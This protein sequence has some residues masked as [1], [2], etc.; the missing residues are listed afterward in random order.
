[1]TQLALSLASATLLFL[2]ALYAYLVW[3]FIRVLKAKRV[4]GVPREAQEH[5]SILRSPKGNPTPGPAP[6][7]LTRLEDLD[8][9]LGILEDGRK[10]DT[11]ALDLLRH[12]WEDLLRRI[13]KLSGIEKRIRDNMRKYIQRAIFAYSKKR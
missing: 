4:S 3:E 5:G 7:G 6:I 12:D 13:H 2:I 11:K 1:M 10:L 9:R 8:H